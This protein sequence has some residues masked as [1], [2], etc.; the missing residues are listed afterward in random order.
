MLKFSGR[1][2]EASGTRGGMQFI[3]IISNIL[4]CLTY[5][6]H[7]IHQTHQLC[8]TLTSQ[9][10]Q[11]IGQSTL[12]IAEIDLAKTPRYTNNPTLVLLFLLIQG[13]WVRRWQRRG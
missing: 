6:V 1:R 4:A 2:R 9:A 5:S 3:I 8:A 13:D 10:A 12:H 11:N 7:R